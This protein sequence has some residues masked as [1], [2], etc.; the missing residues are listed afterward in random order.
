MPA[1]NLKIITPERVVL[2]QQVEQVI[3]RGTAGELAILPGHQPL[4]TS[5]AID[6]LRYSIAGHKEEEAAAVMGGV[7]EVRDNDVTVISDVAELDM[8]I[9]E[10]RAKQSKEKAEAEKTQKQDKIDVYVAEMAVSR[11][12]A[13]LKAAELRRMRRSVQR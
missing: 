1:L 7:L 12:L 2:E 13:R 4:V 9:D 3:A 6:V 10:A 5:L 8:E 11:A